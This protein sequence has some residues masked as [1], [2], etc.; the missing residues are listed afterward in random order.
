MSVVDTEVV[1][2]SEGVT[3][4]LSEAEY[5]RAR[6]RYQFRKFL[7]VAGFL[8]PFVLLWLVFLAIPM[9]WSVWLSF[10]TGGLIDPATFVGFDNWTRLSDDYELRRSLTNTGIYLVIAISVVFGLSFMLAMLVEYVDRG[11]NFFKVALYFPL[12]VPPIMAGMIFLFLTHYDMGALNMMLRV[13]GLE[14]IN[15]L[16]TNPNALLTIV[17]LE[18][19]RGLGFWVL[20]FIAAIQSIPSDLTDAAKVDGAGPMRRFVRV[21]LPS[22]RPLLLFALVIAIIFNAQVFDSIQVLTKGGPILGTTSV[23]WFIYKRLFAFQDIGLAYAT[24]VGLLVI[25][26]LLT[27]A[28]YGVLGPRAGKNQ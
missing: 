17:G 27:I 20:F 21:S 15:F 7:P 9:L 23:V 14:R 6:R 18:V 25:V 13:G 26:V 8:G 10:N 22:L 12:L 19:W 3:P 4:M 2:A 16:G 11:K 28:A 5:A 24:S 1:T